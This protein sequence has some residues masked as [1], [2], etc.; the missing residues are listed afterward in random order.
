MTTEQINEQIKA[1]REVTIELSKSKEKGL[2]F[3]INA[4]I[5]KTNGKS[6]KRKK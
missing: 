6:S 3:L 4:G 5:V 2:Q 1:I